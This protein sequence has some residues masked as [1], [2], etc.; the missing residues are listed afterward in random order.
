MLTFC[1]VVIIIDIMSVTTKNTDVEQVGG[2]ELEVG[3]WRRG[4]ADVSRKM[5][6]GTSIEVSCERD[7]RSLIQVMRTCGFRSTAKKNTGGGYTVT[8]LGTRPRMI[9]VQAWKNGVQVRRQVPDPTG[10]VVPVSV[11]VQISG[12]VYRKLQGYCKDAGVENKEAILQI[13]TAALLRHERYAS[14][15]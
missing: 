6:A 13:V 1:E 2:C 4:W 11:T 14:A 7:M 9:W 5:E 8:K 3:P 12:D 10:V 15:V